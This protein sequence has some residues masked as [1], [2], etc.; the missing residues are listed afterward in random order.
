MVSLL[1]IPVV[2]EVGGPIILGVGG[3]SNAGGFLVAGGALTAGSLD[4]AVRA[5]PVEGAQGN[6]AGSSFTGLMMGVVG[7]ATHGRVSDAV[8]VGGFLLGVGETFKGEKP[9]Y[10]VRGRV[11]QRELCSRGPQ[12]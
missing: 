9:G 11:R 3:M 12:C 5:Y 8:G 2:G 6:G 4:L 1:A 10:S 7:V